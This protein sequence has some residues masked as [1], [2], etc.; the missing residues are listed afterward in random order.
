MSG[1]FVSFPKECIRLEL[2][3]PL[4]VNL[5]V[6]TVKYVSDRGD[7]SFVHLEAFS[8]LDVLDLIQAELALEYFTVKVLLLDVEVESVDLFSKLISRQC[9]ESL[10]LHVKFGVFRA[11]LLAIVE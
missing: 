9:L 4:L 11:V 1:Q 3:S 8:D 6:I 10:L 2:F 7:I 5:I